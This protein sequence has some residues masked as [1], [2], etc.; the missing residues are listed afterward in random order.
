MREAEGDSKEYDVWWL[1]GNRVI[2]VQTSEDLISYGDHS[3]V[4]GLECAIT[5]KVRYAVTRPEGI[6]FFNTFEEAS[7]TLPE[8][9][10]D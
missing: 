7:Q 8:A 1:L 10:H 4:Y 9:P 6:R 2:G 3:K 5:K